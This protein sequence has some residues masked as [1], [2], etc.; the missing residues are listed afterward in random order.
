MYAFAYARP[1]SLAEARTLLAS[2]VEP[3]LLAGGQTLLPSM[4]HRLTAQS[5]LI[6]LQDIPEL[7]GIREEEGAIVVGAM[8]RHAQVASSV[9]VRSRIPALA[10]LAGGIADPSVRNMGTIGGSLANSDPAADYPA[11]L[12]GLG[13]TV[14]TDRRAI[15]AD[16]YLIGMFQ[17]ALEPDEIIVAVRFPIP[18]RAGYCKLP[19]RASGYVLAG[20]F[21][22]ETEGIVRVAINGVGDHAFRLS[23]AEQ[24]LAH[25]FGPLPDSVCMPD[26]ELMVDDPAAPAAFKQALVPAAV[27]RAIKRALAPSFEG[28]A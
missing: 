24:A 18:A 27:N 28:K 8:A 25:E 26:I 5:T 21:V 4:K 19:N 20:A 17:T 22:S 9:I 12:V 13:G 16:D 14:L 11:A 1:E 7:Q 3:R 23:A 15:E 6:D 10:V 2:D